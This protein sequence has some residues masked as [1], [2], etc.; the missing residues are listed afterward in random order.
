MLYMS[1]TGNG[2]VNWIANY[3][4]HVVCIWLRFL[5]A[6]AYGTTIFSSAIKSIPENQFK[7][8]RVDGAGEMGRYLSILLFQT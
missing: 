2:P 4:F 5:P 1:F 8:A 3:P 7:A 6:W